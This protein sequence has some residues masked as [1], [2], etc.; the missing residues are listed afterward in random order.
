MASVVP[1][2]ARDLLPRFE[3]GEGKTP[4]DLSPPLPQSINGVIR[5]GESEQ[6]G[7]QLDRLSDIFKAIHGC[8]RPPRGSGFTGQ[9]ITL[10][11]SFKRDGAVL[12]KPRITF[13]KSG[14]DSDQRE[15]F[16]NSVIDAFARCTPLPVTEKLGAAIAGRPFTF[17]F[18]DTRPM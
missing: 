9:E 2:S 4:Y 6:S 14:G 13:Y 1:G 16:Q 5:P 12:G 15:A 11:V 10:L 7:G 18:V 17:R 3:R 8:W